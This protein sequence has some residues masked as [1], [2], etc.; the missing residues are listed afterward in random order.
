MTAVAGLVDNGK[1]WM[2]ADSAGV[3]GLSLAIRS[4]PKI[5]KTG[6]FLIGYTSSFRMGQI[7]R[8][9]LSPPVPHEKQADFEYMVKAFVPAVRTAL[10][11]HGY[12]KYDN[13]R[14]TIGTFLVGRRG[15]LFMIEDD[16]QVGELATPYAAVG[17]GQDLAL[18]SLHTT[19]AM[20]KMRAFDRIDAALKAAEAFSAGVRGPFVIESI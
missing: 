11:D 12:L 3:G 10:K 4:D 1:V 17:C 7:L 19:H 8:Y 15:K 13:S 20:K 9:F 14:E 16:L 6:E 18:G 5:F 2:G